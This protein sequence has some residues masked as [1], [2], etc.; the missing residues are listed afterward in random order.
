MRARVY[1][2][3]LLSACVLQMKPVT[4]CLALAAVAAVVAAGAAPVAFTASLSGATKPFLH[5][6]EKCFGSGHALLGL[7]QVWRAVAC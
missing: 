7:R 3:V 6:V 1:G 4:A 5:T 2:H